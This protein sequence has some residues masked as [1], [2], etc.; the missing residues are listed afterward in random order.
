MRLVVKIAG[1]LLESE[2]TVQRLAQQVVHA[3]AGRARVAGDSRRR[4]DFHRDVEAHGHREPIRRR[5]ARDRSRDA[6]RRRDGFRRLAQ[7]ASFGG[8]FAGGPARHRNFGGRWRL[9]PRRTDEPQRSRWRTWDLSAILTG[10]DV[11]FLES[12]WRANLI[13][14]ASCLGLGSDGELYNI[15][16]DHM[17]AACAEY[18]HADRLIF[19]DRRRRRPR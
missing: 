7:Q 17:A 9:F 8:D 5:I 16:A 3:G 15:N 14:V 12:L 4:K 6:R 1:A 11:E 2:E 13:P 19:L 10:V 18:C